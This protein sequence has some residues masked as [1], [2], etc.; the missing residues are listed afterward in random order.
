M[1]EPLDGMDVGFGWIGAIVAPSLVGV[2]IRRLE[3]VTW[4][5]GADVACQFWR[6]CKV[7]TRWLEIGESA[8]GVSYYC[9]GFGCAFWLDGLGFGGF[10]LGFGLGRHDAMSRLVDSL[11]QDD[12]GC[13]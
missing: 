10:G 7:G 3:I 9:G 5:S 2:V 4:R 13:G 12:L 8:T 1:I 6:A 11:Q